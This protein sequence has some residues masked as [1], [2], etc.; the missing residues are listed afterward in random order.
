MKIEALKRRQQD[1]IDDAEAHRD[2][3]DLR[4]F[5]VSTAGGGGGA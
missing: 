2:N 1:V 5:V 3:L 4:S